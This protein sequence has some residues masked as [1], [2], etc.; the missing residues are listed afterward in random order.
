MLSSDGFFFLS[1]LLSQIKTSDT[2]TAESGSE[3][4]DAAS[5]KP[6]GSY[7]I[8]RLTPVSEEVSSFS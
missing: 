5:P 6:T 2:S 4:E 8:P 7:L 1:F 3:V